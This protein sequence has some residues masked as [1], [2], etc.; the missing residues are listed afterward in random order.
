LLAAVD[1]ETLRAQADPNDLDGD[2]ISG[3]VNTVW[4]YEGK[5]LVTGRFG[6]KANQPSLRQQTAGAFVG[7]L[8]ITS[9]LF[10][11]ENHTTSYA[12]LHKFVSMPNDEQ[13]ELTAKIL[14]RVTAYLQTLAPPA[15]RDVS[16][17]TVR[18][19]QR[20]FAAMKCASCHTPELKTGDFHEL[21]ELRNQTIRPYT[22]LLLHDMGKG[23]A[24]GREDFEASG[25]EWRTP[26]LW[27]I[28][29]QE[30]VNGHTT[31]LHDGRARNL[32]EAILWHGGEAENSREQFLNSTKKERLALLSFLQSL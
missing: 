1:D 24:D 10:P 30:R 23:L 13:P 27:G 8:G 28:G 26:P 11:D 14:Q 3:K 20:L 17:P 18:Q 15:R 7:D 25:Q 5:K 4:D 29:L 21:A 16:D 22:D 12:E 2:G 19:G 31:L 6:W 32:T 9:P